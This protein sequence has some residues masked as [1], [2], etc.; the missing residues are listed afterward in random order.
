MKDNFTIDSSL[1]TSSTNN[2]ASKYNSTN[3]KSDPNKEPKP[4]LVTPIP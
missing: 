2:T 4:V 3:S 1:Y